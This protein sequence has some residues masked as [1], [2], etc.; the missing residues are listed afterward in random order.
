MNWVNEIVIKL[1][2][3]KK[4]RLYKEKK[5]REGLCIAT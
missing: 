3:R 5:K 2:K 4:I 1:E